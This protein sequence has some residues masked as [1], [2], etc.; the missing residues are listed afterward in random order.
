MNSDNKTQ[1]YNVI[2]NKSI[3]NNLLKLIMC[4]EKLNLF[5][6]NQ[7]LNDDEIFEKY[8]VDSW[9]FNCLMVKEK[10]EDGSINI[11]WGEQNI[12]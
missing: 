8:G 6:K 11:T 2:Y 5:M 1:V 10:N 4:K 12:I 3:E 9:L 7:D